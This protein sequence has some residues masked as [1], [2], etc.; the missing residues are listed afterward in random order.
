M[1]RRDRWITG[2]LHHDL[3]H[4]HAF[5]ALTSHSDQV[6]HDCLGASFQHMFNNCHVDSPLT[7]S[8]SRALTPAPYA[9]TSAPP[10]AISTS[11]RNAD[12]G[13]HQKPRLQLIL[14]RR[15]ACHRQNDAASTKT[16]QITW[17]IEKCGRTNVLLF[18]R[19]NCRVVLARAGIDEYRSFP[20][21]SATVDLAL[22]SDLFSPVEYFRRWEN[23]DQLM[24]KW[25]TNVPVYFANIGFGS[26]QLSNDKRVSGYM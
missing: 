11:N 13:W 7:F 24:F 9:T 10:N 4:F 21:Y 20:L 2:V 1:R 18:R 19:V 8:R 6:V 5:K 15:T 22:Q 17:V 26:D 14:M 3:S 16:T 23:A 25:F 12:I